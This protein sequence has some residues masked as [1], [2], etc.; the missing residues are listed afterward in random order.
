MGSGSN[1]LQLRVSGSLREACKE[2]WVV[3]RVILTLK[4][5]P[6]H[7]KIETDWNMNQK[8]LKP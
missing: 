3:I 6:K 8:D 2:M 7:W 1:Y 4:L 5:H